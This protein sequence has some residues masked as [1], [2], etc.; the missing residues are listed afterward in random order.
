MKHIL[1][2]ILFI[3]GATLS[4]T[5]ISAIKIDLDGR[6]DNIEMAFKNCL[7]HGLTAGKGSGFTVARNLPFS[8]CTQT[9]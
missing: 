1:T 6:K 7:Q 3:A 9:F 4:A 2:M 5:L 8:T